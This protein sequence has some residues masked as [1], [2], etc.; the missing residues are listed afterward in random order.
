MK[1]QQYK[2]E[3]PAGLQWPEDERFQYFAIDESGHAHFFTSK[4][5]KYTDTG[6]WGIANFFE[7]HDILF[8]GNYFA[9]ATKWKNT[10]I[11]RPENIN[12]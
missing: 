3:L 1:E 4:P 5:K 2:T 9:G 7:T 10:A 8:V 11:Q 12:Q 6:K